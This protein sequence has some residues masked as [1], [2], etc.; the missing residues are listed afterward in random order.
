[1]QLWSIL[2]PSAYHNTFL[3]QVCCLEGVKKG[4]QVLAMN[5]VSKGDVTTNTSEET[6]TSSV[7]ELREKAPTGGAH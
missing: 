7:K 2:E 3:L 5:K 1:M 6:L 4:E